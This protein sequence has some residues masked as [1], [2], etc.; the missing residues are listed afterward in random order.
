M[1]QAIQR[2]RALFVLIDVRSQRDPLGQ[3]TILGNVQKQWLI[4]KLTQCKND[5]TLTWCV[6]VTPV[7]YN[8]NQDKLDSWH[9]YLADTQWLRDQIAALQVANVLVV[10]GD[11]HWGS[12]VRKPLSPLDELN[13]PKVNEGF[14]NTCN[15]HPEQWTLNSTTGK[16]GFGLLTLRTNEAVMAIYNADAGGTLRFSSTVPVQSGGGGGADADGDGVPDD[17]DQC[18]AVPGPAPSGGP[19]PEGGDVSQT[20]TRTTDGGQFQVSVPPYVC[21]RLIGGSSLLRIIK[22]VNG[23]EQILKSVAVQNPAKGVPFTLRCQV[24]SAAVNFYLD[25]VLKATAA[26]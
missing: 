22:V 13:I 17:T 21:R 3:K 8:P 18:P 14:G 25:G 9:G 11:C 15:N 26:P 4:E 6:L 10:S 2:G 19:P 12:I 23:V 20:F 7:P 24:T 1:W 16:P 5:P